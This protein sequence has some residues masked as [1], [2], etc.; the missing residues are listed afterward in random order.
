M[1]K[2]APRGVIPLFFTVKTLERFGLKYGP[3]SD[4]FV[5]FKWLSKEDLLKEIAENGVMSDFSAAKKQ[6]ELCPEKCLFV[7]DKTEQYGEKTL[8]YFTGDSQQGFL[9]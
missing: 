9:K 5:D 1:P 6:I 7:I 8:L 3:S 4:D 2:P